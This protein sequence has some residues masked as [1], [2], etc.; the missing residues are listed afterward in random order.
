MSYLLKAEYEKASGRKWYETEKMMCHVPHIP[1]VEWLERKIEDHVGA[2]P[3][4]IQ[5][6]LNSGDGSYHP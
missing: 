1:Y 6:A 5:Q 4:S 2:L 3:D